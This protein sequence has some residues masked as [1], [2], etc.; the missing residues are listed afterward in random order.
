MSK[1]L[2]GRAKVKP[3]DIMG[4]M[5]EHQDS[6]PKAIRQSIGR[7]ENPERQDERIVGR[8]MT[9]DWA[10]KKVERLVDKEARGVSS[11]G[12]GHHLPQDGNDWQLM[13]TFSLD[14]LMTSIEN[15]T[16]TILPSLRKSNHLIAYQGKSG[17]LQVLSKKSSSFRLPDL[18]DLEPDT[19]SEL[20]Q[21]CAN[22]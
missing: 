12:G 20:C 11:K 18:A 9:R 4:L 16:P 10:I 14:N 2:Q 15:T 22:I 19:T 5:Y 8:G 21:V 1:F 13:H 3:D 17:I 7:A 6:R